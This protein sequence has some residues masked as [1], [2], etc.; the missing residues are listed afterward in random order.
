MC[1]YR[2]L[3]Q[4]GWAICGSMKQN[5]VARNNKVL[6]SSLSHFPSRVILTRDLLS[7]RPLKQGKGRFVNHP[8]ALKVSACYDTHCL[9][10]H[11]PARRN[12]IHMAMPNLTGR[13]V[14]P[15]SRK[16]EDR[17]FLENSTNYRFMRGSIQV[18]CQGAWD[19]AGANPLPAPSREMSPSFGALPF[20]L[21]CCLLCRDSSFGDY[22]VWG[23][24]RE[25]T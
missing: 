13:G 6:F 24:R 25:G 16:A 4:P 14:L 21:L 1:Q 8:P 23:L 9:Y 10:S 22:L 20:Q 3:S 17:K 18:V 7:L 19:P 15:C 12:H 5:S 11:F 2:P